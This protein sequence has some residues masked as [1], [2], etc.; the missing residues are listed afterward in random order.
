VRSFFFQKFFFSTQN[1]SEHWFFTPKFW[2]KIEKHPKCHIC[3]QRYKIQAKKP[4]LSS[5]IQNSGEK[6]IFVI[7][8]TKYRLLT[9]YT[10]PTQFDALMTNLNSD[11][12][13]FEVKKCYS[14]N[15]KILGRF[16]AALGR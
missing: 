11:L 6:T 12:K 8:D 5:T 14:R 1:P 16:S 13:N 7:S 4:F 15:I 3:H 9:K 10:I 2:G